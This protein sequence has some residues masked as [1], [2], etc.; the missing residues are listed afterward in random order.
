MTDVVLFHHAQG[1][2]TGIRAFADRLAAAGHHV[3]TPDLYDGAT[4]DTRD[5]GVAHGEELG[6]RTV[7][8]RGRAAVEGLPGAACRCRCTRW[9][10]TR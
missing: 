10:P 3:T 9:R 2:T 6:F 4:F 1:L 8:E 7:L 5:A